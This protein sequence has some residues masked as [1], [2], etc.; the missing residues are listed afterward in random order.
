MYEES[1]L[2]VLGSGLYLWSKLL[3]VGALGVTCRI[4]TVYLFE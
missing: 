2:W 4:V 3:L 1:G